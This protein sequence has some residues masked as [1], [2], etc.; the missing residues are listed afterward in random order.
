MKNTEKAGA[1]PGSRSNY[2]QMVAAL[3]EA[4]K[5]FINRPGDLENQLSE[6]IGKALP[7][8]S[9]PALATW[10][11]QDD[12]STISACYSLFDE[13]W[14]LMATVPSYQENDE[15]RRIAELIVNAVADVFTV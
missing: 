15:G 8:P 3:R 13:R 11:I 9:K 6:M 5:Y 2:Q 4:E 1:T 7:Q 10:T 14:K 12:S